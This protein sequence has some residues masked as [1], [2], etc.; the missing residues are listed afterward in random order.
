MHSALCPPPQNLEPFSEP[1][2]TGLPQA[3]DIRAQIQKIL[4]STLFSKCGRLT[5]FI[6]FA[7]QHV[8]RGT[9]EPLKEYVVGVEVFDRACSYDPRIDPIVRVEARRLRSKLDSYYSSVGRE[10]PVLI[11]FPKGTYA[12]VFRTRTSY[13]TMLRV[14]VANDVGSQLAMAVLPFTLLTAKGLDDGFAARFN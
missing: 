8:L 14:M 5:R 1:H 2:R 6:S 7:A 3:A 11:E 12:P 13:Q 9:G 10:D 4:E